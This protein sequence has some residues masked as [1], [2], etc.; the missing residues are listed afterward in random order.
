[1]ADFPLPVDAPTCKT[2]RFWQFQPEQ[3]SLA[4]PPYYE[5]GIC[6]KR[7]PQA[8]GYEGGQDTIWP[9]VVSK[10]WCGEH[11]ARG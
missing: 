1:M 8:F 11:E 6:R 5:R 9:S 3:S 4:N 2:C 10:D 7:P